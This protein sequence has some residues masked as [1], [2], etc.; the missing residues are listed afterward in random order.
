MQLN[1]QVDA[2]HWKCGGPCFPEWFPS[3]SQCMHPRT[4][5]VFAAGLI[6]ELGARGICTEIW[7][8]TSVL[9]QG[10]GELL[11]LHQ[12]CT[13][14]GDT[15]VRVTLVLSLIHLMASACSRLLGQLF[16]SLFLQLTEAHS[17]EGSSGTQTPEF[18]RK[19]NTPA[20][21]FWATSSP[22]PALLFCNTWVGTSCVLLKAQQVLQLLILGEVSVSACCFLSRIICLVALR[23]PLL[24]FSLHTVMALASLIFL[25]L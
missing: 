1:L 25:L 5:T 16:V 8:N 21:A 15:A 20:A 24:Q 13:E 7:W 19:H 18:R 12:A 11:P 3:F 10:E 14:V 6:H 4:G 2:V 23:E 9:P 17:L 22:I